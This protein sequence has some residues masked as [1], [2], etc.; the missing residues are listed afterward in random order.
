MF[1]FYSLNEFQHEDCVQEQAPSDSSQCC[2]GMSQVVALFT[3]V[4]QLLL[5]RSKTGKGILRTTVFIVSSSV[6]Q[7]L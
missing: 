7:R 1:H 3:S 5:F 6:L 4:S 2:A